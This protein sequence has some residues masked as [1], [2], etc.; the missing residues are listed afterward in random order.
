MTT[1]PYQLNLNGTLFDLSRPV[2][3]AIINL[4]PDSFYKK[5][6]IETEKEL[7]IRVEKTISEGA[8]ILDIG[9]YSTRPNAT[10][11]STEE[12]LERLKKGLKAIRKEFP[13]VIISVDTFRSK[14]AEFVVKE[15]GVQ[16]INDISGGTLDKKMFEMV[17][18]LNV[19]YIL[20][21]MKGTPQTMTQMTDYE[22]LMLEIMDFFQKKIDVL[23]DLGVKDVILD[24]GFGFAK[25]LE[26]NYELMAKMKYLKEFELP[27]LSGISR[28][29]MIFRLLESTPEES[30]NGTTALNLL[31][32][33]EGANILRVHDVKEAVEVVRIFEMYD[34]YLPK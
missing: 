12:E 20:M 1:L 3:M 4:T 10:P 9:G 24:P 18:K 17:A 5:S 23:M 7:L 15:F 21:H 2:V 33:V 11:V 27:I 8:T 22:N 34:K 28:K 25:T 14:I 29:S 26:Q 6:R 31:S 30:L 32:L 19:V 16:I 13:N